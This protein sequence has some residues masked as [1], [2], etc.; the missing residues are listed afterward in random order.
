MKKKY[1]LLLCMTTA[2]V[3][4]ACSKTGFSPVA[5]E[6]VTKE[7]V[8][9]VDPVT[10]D[11]PETPVVPV[12]PSYSFKVSNGACNQ[13]SSTSVIS[14]LKCD[15]PTVTPKLQLSAKAQALVDVM[16]LACQIKN[17]SDLSDYRPTKEQIIEKLNRGSDE[18][19]PDTPRTSRMEQVIQGLTNTSDDSLRKKMFG[20]LW[21]K[22]PYSDAF[23]TYFGLAVQEAKSTF[24]W[25]G[26]KQT[27][28][29]TNNVGYY[30]IDWINC[31]HSEN[32]DPFNCKERPE[33]VLGLG[34]RNQLQNVLKTSVEQPYSKPI[35]D[36]QAKC[37]WEK[38][39]GDDIIE[40]IKQVKKWKSEG[41]KI[42]MSVIK[43][44]AVGF[45]GD[46]SSTILKPG[47]TVELGTFSCK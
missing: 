15:V 43:G 17:K 5:E 2:M 12:D 13:D 28:Q 4:S 16:Y 33:Y 22:P 25:D 1:Q 9:P 44:D 8:I 14:C 3:F 26:D 19:Y 39:E 31:T 27:K 29:I 32:G 24:C 6:V 46:A 30:S 10:P 38:F 20:G 36:P 47:M 18:L 34:Y 42:A 45:C 7:E 40:A 11:V 41:K 23:E 21:Y 35:P 37:S